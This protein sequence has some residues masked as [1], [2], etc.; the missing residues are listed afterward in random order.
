M[1]RCS[2]RSCKGNK[3]LDFQRSSST[4]VNNV[5]TQINGNTAFLDASFVYGSDGTRSR[6]LRALDGSGHLATSTGNLMPFNLTNLAN[7]PGTGDPTTFFLGGDVR[8]NE[9]LALC[10]MQTLF[11]REHNSW[12]DIIKAA[13]STLDDDGIYF[14]ARAIV[15]AEIQSITYRD[16]V[17]ILLGPNALTPYTGYKSSADPR[18]AIAYS[19]AAF[20]VGHTFLPP[21][22]KSF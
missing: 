7:Q 19:T 4:L 3:I 1:I 22:L 6:T 12:A 16:F 11:M 15:C 8:S 2:I 9:N 17:P 5:R 21:V 10:A 13:D 18:V 20:R 14:R